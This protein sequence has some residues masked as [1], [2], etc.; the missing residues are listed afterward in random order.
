MKMS[1]IKPNVK[2][3]PFDGEELLEG[4]VTGDNG[5]GYGGVDENGEKDPEAKQYIP[6]EFHSVW[7]D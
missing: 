6:S 4:S 1:Y 3:L 2:I 7:A 5:I